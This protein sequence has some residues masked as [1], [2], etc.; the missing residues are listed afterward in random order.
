[1]VV[2]L[3]RGEH[4]GAV[5]GDETDAEHKKQA[6]KSQNIYEV[7]EQDIKV[8][9][10]APLLLPGRRRGLGSGLLRGNFFFLIHG[11]I[12]PEFQFQC[13][14]YTENPNK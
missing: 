7:V 10:Q 3:Q 8:P 4:G 11:Q 12:P 2:I 6:H 14:L 5:H 1:M 9:A 13:P